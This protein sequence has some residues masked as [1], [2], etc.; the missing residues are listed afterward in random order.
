MTKGQSQ[1][2]AMLR[3][4]L[5]GNVHT[6]G[7]VE[8]LKRSMVGAFVIVFTM[9]GLVTSA[10]AVTLLPPGTSAIPDPLPAPAGVLLATTGPN[11][12]SA[13]TAL[14]GTYT[15]Q[16]WTEGT[17]PNQACPTGA[18][19]T[20]LY[21][22]T[23]NSGS[24]EWINRITM[25]SFAGFLVD[26][27][28]TI[29]T[30]GTDRIVPTSVD[31]NPAGSTIGYTFSPLPFGVG[32]VGP[33]QATVLL[34]IQTNATSYTKGLLGISQ[35]STISIPDS[36]FVPSAVAVPEPT[37]FLLLGSG[38]IGLGFLIRRRPEDPLSP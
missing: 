18:C 36:V 16:V 38:L 30:T 13:S 26:A 1:E 35:G 37:S 22:I 3:R 33:N 12:W 23:N 8:M 20:F 4:S 9:L 25:T 34:E 14:F 6:A 5:A 31:R 21:Q 10:S 7:G 15:S 27:G 2:G 28:W 29:G 11:N 19:L 32:L 17:T 24:T